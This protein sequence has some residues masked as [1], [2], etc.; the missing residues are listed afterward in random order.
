[1]TPY[2][3][4]VAPYWFSI[5]GWLAEYGRGLGWG[6]CPIEAVAQ[7]LE[8]ELAACRE[9]GPIEEQQQ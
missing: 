2:E 5:G 7:A 3:L 1:M 4:R 8:M 9:H 6:M